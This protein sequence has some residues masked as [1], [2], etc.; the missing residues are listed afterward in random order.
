MTRVKH[1]HVERVQTG[2]IS[3]ASPEGDTVGVDSLAFRGHKLYGVATGTCG[4]DPTTLPPEI[5]TQLGKVLRLRGGTDVK[6]VFDPQSFECSKNP[7]GQEA[8]TDPYGLC[9][10]TPHD[11]G[12]RRSLE[13]RGEV[14]PQR[15]AAGLRAVD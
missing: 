1:G 9:S 6:A 5:A 4:V 3:V 10:S 11:L 14:P 15:R 7:D 12:C 8:D 2:L 13:R